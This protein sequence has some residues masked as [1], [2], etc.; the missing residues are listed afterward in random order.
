LD[1]IISCLCVGPLRLSANLLGP[2]AQ[3][4]RYSQFVRKLHN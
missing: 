4:D 3:D 1:S 2:A